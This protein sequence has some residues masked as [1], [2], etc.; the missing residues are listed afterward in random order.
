VLYRWAAEPHRGEQVGRVLL[1][2]LGGSGAVDRRAE[3][4]RGHDRGPSGRV[5]ATHPA[6]DR[7]VSW[8][9]CGWHRA[10][11]AEPVTT[12]AASSA[13]RRPNTHAG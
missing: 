1:C 8:A 3:R 4:L 6:V 11:T 2:T 7:T 12:A 13:R 9:R 5:L 10:R